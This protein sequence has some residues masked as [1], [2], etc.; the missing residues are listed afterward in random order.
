MADW[1]EQMGLRHFGFND[2]Q[3]SQI[4]AAIP[5]AEVILAFLKSHRTIVNE[6]IDVAE[7]M[8]KQFAQ[9]QKENPQ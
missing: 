3:I 5:K 7:M 2:D 1:M 4:D 8:T 9:F 6:L